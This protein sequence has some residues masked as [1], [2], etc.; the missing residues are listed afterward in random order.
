VFAQIYNAFCGIEGML[1]RHK[2]VPRFP[3]YTEL[4]QR[5]FQWQTHPEDL[6]NP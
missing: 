6:P 5:S 3:N 4:A 2:S 1:L